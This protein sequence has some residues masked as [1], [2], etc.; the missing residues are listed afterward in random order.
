MHDKKIN[1]NGCDSKLQL[2]NPIGKGTD[3]N[4]HI[5]AYSKYFHK[6]CFM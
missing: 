6:L 2:I 1:A 3:T 4:S 5:I